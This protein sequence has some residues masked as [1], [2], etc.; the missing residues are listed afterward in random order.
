MKILVADVE[1]S[2]FA[3]TDGVCQLAFIEV[4]PDLEIIAEWDGL[5]D[6]QAPISPGAQ[7]VHGISDADVEFAPTMIELMEEILIPQFGKFDD[8]LLVAHNSS[9]DRRFLAPHW[10]ISNT[11][12]TMTA[13]R[14]VF[15]NSPDFKLRTLQFYLGLREGIDEAHSAKDDTAILLLLLKKLIYESEMDLFTLLGY[16]LS[17]RK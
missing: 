14:K 3:K 9:F 15:P 5:V 12:C 6:P 10:G 1:T 16:T 13:S 2:G 11:F 8:V 7:G 17:P 4:N